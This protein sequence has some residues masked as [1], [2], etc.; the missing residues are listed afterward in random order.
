[1]V[2]DHETAKASN[3]RQCRQDD[4]LACTLRGTLAGF[5]WGLE[6]TIHEMNAVVDGHTHKQGDNN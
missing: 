5:P 2:R 6:S 4:G 3:R 1:M